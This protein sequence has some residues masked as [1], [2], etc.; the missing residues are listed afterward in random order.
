MVNALTMA[1]FSTKNPISEINPRAIYS[2]RD[3][4]PLSPYYTNK[5]FNMQYT[6][7][8]SSDY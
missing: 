4:Q 2:L 8:H 5:I 1:A 3:I 7:L 6:R